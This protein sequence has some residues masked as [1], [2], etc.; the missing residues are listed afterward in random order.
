[1]VEPDPER[2]EGLRKVLA[3]RARTGVERGRLAA[4]AAA[5]LAELLVVAG[6]VEELDTGLDLVVETVPSASS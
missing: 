5:A 3:D 1:M 2:A 6:R 4:A